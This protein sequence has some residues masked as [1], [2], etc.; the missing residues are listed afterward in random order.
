[1]FVVVALLLRDEEEL[2]LLNGGEV[3]EPP[4]PPPPTLLFVGRVNE[5][6]RLEVVQYL[7]PVVRPNVVAILPPPTTMRPSPINFVDETIAAIPR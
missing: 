3:R 2:L 1:M 4:P 5:D 7:V 6:D